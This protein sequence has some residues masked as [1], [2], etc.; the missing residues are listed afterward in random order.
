MTPDI[1]Q[2]RLKSGDSQMIQE[3]IE[4]DLRKMAAASGASKFAPIDP[5]NVVTANWVRQKCRFGCV[6]YGTRL[7]CPPFSPSPDETRKVLGEYTKAYLVGFDGLLQSGAEST[8]GTAMSW[9]EHGNHIRK[10]LFELER[11]AFLSGYYKAFSYDI[12][13]CKKC[14]KCVVT[15]G[16]TTCRFPTE[17]RPSM[18]AAGIDVYATVRNAGLKMA[19]VKDRAVTNKED[20][21]LYTLLLLE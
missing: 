2:Y 18:E 15:D 10:T 9:T 3:A 14:E 13:T 19:V 7:A 11:H 12:G 16:R 6:N 17:L 1:H 5:K 8:E 4:N 20:V 21:Q